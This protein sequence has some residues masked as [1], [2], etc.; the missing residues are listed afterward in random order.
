[1]KYYNLIYLI[2]FRLFISF[3]EKHI[4]IHYV[5]CQYV[6]CIYLFYHRSHSPILQTLSHGLWPS[7]QR[8]SNPIH[9]TSPQI[10]NKFRYGHGWD[11]SD[12]RWGDGWDLRP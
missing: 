4:Y 11:L 10:E 12:E 8:V 2:L 9:Q 3:I 1:M 5:I 7:T 6:L